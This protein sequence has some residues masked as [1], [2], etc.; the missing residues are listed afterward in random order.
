MQASGRVLLPSNSPTRYVAIRLPYPPGTAK[1]IGAN[2]LRQARKGLVAGDEVTLARRT[3]QPLRDVQWC[4]C[5]SRRG[6]YRLGGMDALRVLAVDDFAD[7]AESTAMLLGSWGH[8][9]G[10]ARWAAD[11]LHAVHTQRPHV[12]LL[13][14]ALPRVRDGLALAR[15]VRPFVPLVVAV[16]GCVGVEPQCLE[17]GVDLVLTKPVAPDDLQAL[18]AEARRRMAQAKQLRAEARTL[19]AELAAAWREFQ[20]LRQAS[21]AAARDGRIV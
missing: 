9:A 21:P 1:A 6:R 12:V 20:R 8:Q 11:A 10:A 19:C 16:T 3:R 15:Q 13:D 7:T 2:S 17:A 14:L 5:P 18:L 4:P